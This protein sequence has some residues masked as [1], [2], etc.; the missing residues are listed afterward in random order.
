MRILILLF[1]VTTSISCSDN[2]TNKATSLA[3]ADLNVLKQIELSVIDEKLPLQLSKT[4]FDKK[5]NII[6]LND[7]IISKIEQATKTYYIED[8]LNDSLHTYHDTYIKTVRLHDSLQTIYLVLLKHYPTGL[9]NSKV[10]FYDNQKKEFIDKTFDF[11]LHALYNFENSKLKPT[12]LKR[13][14][15]ITIPEIETTD[16]DKDGIN[17]FKFTR[18]FHNGTFNAI[19]TTILTV[20]NSKID[21]LNFEESV[22]K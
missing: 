19:Q 2:D 9:V 21:T 11:N 16:F 13:D 20:K 1:L 14:F 15:E 7:G 4:D 12:N 5:E 22:L 8:C 6:Q 18:L 3:T 10:L 17:D